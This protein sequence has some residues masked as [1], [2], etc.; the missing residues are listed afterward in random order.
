MIN[1][2]QFEREQ[3]SERVALGCHARAM[4]GLLNGGHEIL[5]FDKSPE[6]KSTYIVNEIEAEQIRTAFRTF[7]ECG[8]LNRTATRLHE[9]GIKPKVKAN[10]ANKIVDRGLWT[11][12]SLGDLLKNHA[13]V[14]MREVNRG[15]KGDVSTSLKPHQQYQLV[16]ATWPAIVDRETFDAVQ[17]ALEE[18]KELE[19]RRLQGA[20]RRVFLASGIL[21]CKDCGRPMIGQSAHGHVKAHRYYVHG[22]SKGDVITCAVKRIRAEEVEEAIARHISTVLRD[23]KYLDGVAERIASQGKE[24]KEGLRGLRAKIQKEIKDAESEMETA[25]KFQAQADPGSEG[26]KFFIEKIDAVGKRKAALKA[27]LERTEETAANIVSLDEVRQGLEHRVEMVA[28]GWRKLQPVQQKRALRR[29]IANILIGKNG[30]DIEYYYNAI[31]RGGTSEGLLMESESSAKVLQFGAR[32]TRFSDSKRQVENCL[33]ARMATT[34]RI[35]LAT[36]C[37][38]NLR[39]IRLNFLCNGELALWEV[40]M[41]I[42]PDMPGARL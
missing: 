10:R 6:R 4:R 28:K 22:Y 11:H 37:L 33:S 41:G 18:N 16:K 24:S 35:E 40:K 32:G 36:C 42:C 2:A 19:R 20:E 15:N 12:Q 7:L 9:L 1:L 27:E 5:G 25:F 13:Y 29:L 39:Y 30:L 34:A 3:T 31:P 14:G 8:T 23:G 17:R 21:K 26:A 38:G